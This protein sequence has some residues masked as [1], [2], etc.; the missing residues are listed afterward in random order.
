MGGEIELVFGPQWNA[1]LLNENTYKD[2]NASQNNSKKED[3]S[4]KDNLQ[5]YTQH[6]SRKQ[7][8]SIE[9]LLKDSQGLELFISKIEDATQMASE[10]RVLIHKEKIEVSFAS[11]TEADIFAQY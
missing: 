10:K 4:N 1:K 8:N 11:Q 5:S 3:R 9:D 2:I 7:F 6:E